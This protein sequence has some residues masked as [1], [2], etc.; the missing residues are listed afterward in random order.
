VVMFG[1]TKPKH[2]D[3]MLGP[4]LLKGGESEEKALLLVTSTDN[5]RALP[6]WA[7]R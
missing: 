3:P 5:G 4:G 2:L 7:D 6:L 1:E